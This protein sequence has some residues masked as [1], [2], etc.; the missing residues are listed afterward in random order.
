MKHRSW[1]Y[2]TPAKQAGVPARMRTDESCA[3]FYSKNKGVPASFAVIEFVHTLH[4]TCGEQ[5]QTVSCTEFPVYTVL[6]YCECDTVIFYRSFLWFSPDFIFFSLMYIRNLVV[7][8]I[9]KR[10]QNAVLRAETAREIQQYQRNMLH[11]VFKDFCN[12]YKAV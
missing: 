11:L 10:W 5:K 6:N 8:I 1:A 4:I 7:V 9:N 3:G 12:F 2:K